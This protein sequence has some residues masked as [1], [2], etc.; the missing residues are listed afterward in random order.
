MSNSYIALVHM[1][2]V[3]MLCIMYIPAIAWSLPHSLLETYPIIPSMSCFLYRV[4]H[5]YT[6]T[7][8]VYEWTQTKLYERNKPQLVKNNAKTLDPVAIWQLCSSWRGSI[9]C[10][11]RESRRQ[12]G[13]CGTGCAYEILMK[14]YDES[15]RKGLDLQGIIDDFWQQQ[16]ILSSSHSFLGWE[17]PRTLSK[18]DD[19]HGG[20]L[21]V[22]SCSTHR[23]SPVW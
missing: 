6:W 15:V 2:Y 10:D 20:F 9:R 18:V 21:Y 16:I 4:C 1:I 7:C 19:R 23:C 13:G 8:V 12:K 17:L 22:C 11:A 5:T 3:C 14:S